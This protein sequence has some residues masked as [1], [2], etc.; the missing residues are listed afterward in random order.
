[1]APLEASIHCQ[2]HGSPA[3]WGQKPFHIISAI[4][5]SLPLSKAAGTKVFMKLENVQPTGSFKIRGIGHL[6][7]EAAKKGSTPPTAFSST[8]R[9]CRDGETETRG[10]DEPG[11]HIAGRAGA[12]VL[13]LLASTH[14]ALP[15]GH[16]RYPPLHAPTLHPP[17]VP[18]LLLPELFGL[19]LP[20]SISKRSLSA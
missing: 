18:P 20:T 13:P 19:E 7:Q 15:L 6:C 9:P 2:G 17:P 4:P 8:Q 1:M 12:R 14:P 10:A 5:E 16:A 11:A 3:W